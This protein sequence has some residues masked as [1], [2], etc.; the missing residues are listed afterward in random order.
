MQT[1]KAQLLA[2]KQEYELRIERT[3]KHIT[4]EDG[5]VS[6]DFAEQ[7]TERENEDVV[8]RLDE[9]A[10]YELGLVNKALEKVAAGTYGECE[11]C[12][13]NIAEARLTAVPQAKNC[14]KCEK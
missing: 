13:E 7:A 2:L 14:I 9:E 10:K 11:V 4:H 5:P 3:E 8:H 1:H 12:G 6:Q